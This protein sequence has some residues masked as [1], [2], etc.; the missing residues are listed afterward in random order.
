[1]GGGGVWWGGAGAVGWVGRMYRSHIIRTTCW[2][3]DNLA[4]SL[5]KNCSKD[6]L[7]NEWLNGISNEH[8]QL[9]PIVSWLLLW[10]YSVIEL[11]HPLEVNQGLWF[12]L[13]NEIWME[14]TCVTFCRKHLLLILLVH[15]FCMCKYT[16]LLVCIQNSKAHITF[17]V[18]GGHL[19]VESCE[20]F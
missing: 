7:I 19:P 10:K 14:V 2:L 15:R 8:Q 5:E 1:M 17:L 13:V 11:F 18:T 20:K 3:E 4:M 12:A 9:S 6:G 16:D